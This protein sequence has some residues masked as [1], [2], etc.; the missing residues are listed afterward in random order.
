MEIKA[1]NYYKKEYAD[2]EDF[3][4]Y[5]EVF[6]GPNDTA[7]VYEVFNFYVISIKRLYDGFQN[8]DSDGVMLNRGWMII[9]YYNSKLIEK[10]ILSIINKC[11]KQSDEETYR[12]IGAYLI[13]QDS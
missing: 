5:G 10:E 3:L 9:K 13:R 6:I 2:E 8:N 11:R 7:S 1:I 4:V 12:E